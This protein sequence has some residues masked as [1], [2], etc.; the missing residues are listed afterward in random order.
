[1][2]RQGLSRR[3]FIRLSGGTALAGILPDT[4]AFFS[5]KDKADRPNIL[6]ISVD[7]L[8]PDLG[9][10][11]NTI[12]KTPN[13]DRL[14][15]KSTVFS[16][17]Y[18]QQ[19]LCNPSRASLMTGKRPDSL[20]V[21]DQSTHFRDQNPDIVTLPQFFKKNGYRS[22]GIGKIYHPGLY[23]PKSWS[24]PQPNIRISSYYLSPKTQQRMLGRER[25]AKKLGK[26]MDWIRTVLLG[27]ATEAYD[28]PDDL[29]LD[30]VV[31]DQ[32]IQKLRDLKKKSPF[33]LAVG[34]YR[35]HLPFVAPKK[36]W[37]L[38]DRQQIPLA[39]N[40]FLPE[41][42]P[43]FAINEMLELACYEGLAGIPKPSEGR[44]PEPQA[45]L[46]KHGYYACVSFVDAQIG[47]LLDELE[48][49]R[50]RDNTIIVLFGDH[51][52][53]LGEH[54]SW[55]K[56]TNYEIDTR[57][58]LLISIPDRLAQF[59]TSSAL[60]ELVDIYPTLCE[61]AGLEPPARLEG[62][63]MVPLLDNPDLP[64]KTAVFSQ[65]P[66]GFMGRIMGRSVRTDRYRY[67]E[68]SQ[69]FGGNLVSQEVYD[70]QNDPE[71][72]INIAGRPENKDLVTELSKLL[73][74]GWWNALP[75]QKSPL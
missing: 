41:G 61:L 45:R 68:W 27:P 29:Y 21:W 9:C 34:F 60:V 26:D 40:D 28:A 64:W 36:Y 6:F 5:D 44:L 72:N 56:K 7:D 19:A 35:P 1:M 66:R 12:I 13:I 32:A 25:A 37:D 57:S 11:G 30:A 4:S 39:E 55:G 23:D 70:H 52:W 38:Y 46:L 2:F 50:L 42:A 63:S 75:E 51:G 15:G 65:F 8:R 71:E 31:A 67:V 47:R 48:R 17:A 22:E 73:W 49:L 3:E 14:A 74:K 24:Q 18:C 58:P 20:K 69:W 53:K 10:Y 43:H 33:F 59:Q 16:R 54:R 62:T